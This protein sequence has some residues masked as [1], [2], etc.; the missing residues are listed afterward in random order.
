MEE[1]K[2][3]ST[4]DY[5]DEDKQSVALI[6][7]LSATIGNLNSV[8]FDTV[9]PETEELISVGM[10][11]DIANLKS[12]VS[13]LTSNMDNYVTVK[14]FNETVTGINNDII[15]LAERLAW[16]DLTE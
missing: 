16:T 13:D 10:V 11:T 6:P 4:N 14:T 1:G 5:S 12:A 2:G 3:L 9:D 7:G 15:E 8:I